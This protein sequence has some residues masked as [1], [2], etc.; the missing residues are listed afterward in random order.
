MVGGDCQKPLQLLAAY[1]CCVFE[2][3]VCVDPSGVLDGRPKYA[4]IAF[5]E[6]FDRCRTDRSEVMDEVPDYAIAFLSKFCA[7]AR[8]P[9]ALVLFGVAAAVAQS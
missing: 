5:S 9:P 7:R 3:D 6:L 2:D 8:C 4:N 1:G